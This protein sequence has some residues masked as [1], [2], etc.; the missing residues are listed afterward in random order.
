MT[1]A[2]RSVLMGLAGLGAAAPVG[3]LQAARADDAADDMSVVRRAMELHPGAYRYLSSASLDAA[4]KTLERE[5]QDAAVLAE[6]YLALSRFFSKV[7]CGH[8]YCNFFNQS[9]AVQDDVFNRRTRLPFAFRWIG[10]A[11]VVTAA[12]PETGLVPGVVVQEING[13]PAGQILAELLPYTR[14]DGAAPGKRRAL[15]EMQHRSRIE[16]FDVFHGLA[17][18]APKDHAHVV[19]LRLPDG[20]DATMTLPALT[21]EDRQQARSAVS[22]S[23]K[24]DAPV[25]RWRVDDGGV[26]T[27]TMPT[28]SVYGSDWDWSGWLDERLD[29]ARG[30]RGLIIDNRRNE[31]GLTE[32]GFALMSRLISEPLR[33]P[34][35]R[36]VVRFRSFP[37]DLREHARTWDPSFYE[38]GQDAERIGPNWFALP[39]DGADAVIEPTGEQV[40]VPAVL[41]TS[42]TNSSATFIFAR[43]AQS[44]GRMTLVGETTGGNLRG[45]NGD[46]F[47]FTTLPGSGIEFDLPIVGRFAPTPQPDAG[48]S[49][50][51]AVSD[52]A[53]S[54]AEGRDV[55]LERAREVVLAA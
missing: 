43:L 40:D 7:R 30:V 5:Y 52:T 54:I 47:F 45:I 37:E 46:G 39:S 17:Y 53:Q 33:V 42:P 15:L 11:M 13:V 25:W 34:E 29:E 8:T 19:G 35:Q 10:D 18:G 1:V 9:D 14:A 6:Q 3:G 23:S 55:A 49:P 20:S 32:C 36:R 44:S 31:G 50:D 51:I 27:L 48:L 38:I 24:G 16:Y 26:A 21:L 28:W 12:A 2:R 41:L 4:L 22:G